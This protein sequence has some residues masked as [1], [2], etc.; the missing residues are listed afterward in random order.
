MSNLGTVGVYSTARGINSAG[1]VV[2]IS[3]A[4]NGPSF[5]V[6]W[7]DGAVSD[8]GDAASAASAINDSGQVV[9]FQEIGPGGAMKPFLW[10]PSSPPTDLGSLGQPGGDAWGINS[11]GQVVGLTS[12][13]TSSHAFLWQNN[14]MSDLGTLGGPFSN[15]YS[16]TDDGQVL[17][18]SSFSS[19][20]SQGHAFLW[21]SQH[22]MRDLNDLIDSESR[23]T[24]QDAR[25][26]NDAGQ[27]VGIGINPDGAQHGYL[28][29]LVPEP[30]SILLAVIGFLGILGLARSR[31]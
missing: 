14:V 27:I 22:G 11:L 25:Q 9:G 28:L 12:V 24:L 31:T 15:A 4:T 10:T 8:V 23:W 21:D 2:G 16:I 19:D 3:Q 7:K 30:S 13:D 29:T 20:T 6:L 17:G 26:M 1:D 5:A 18:T